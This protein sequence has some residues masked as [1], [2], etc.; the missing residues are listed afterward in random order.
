MN[1]ASTISLGR[2]RLGPYA[3]GVALAIV[4]FIALSAWWLLYDQRLPGAGDPGRHLSTTLGYADLLR[5]GDLLGMLRFNGDGE[6][7]YPPLVRWIGAV[8]AA[9]GLDVQDWGTLAVNLVFVPL[10]AA[11]C[12]LV[13]RR[14]YG[15][16]AGLLAALFALGTPMVL[17]LFHVFVLDAALAGIVAISLAA[18]LASE[19]FERRRESV[20]TGAL[21]GVGL[22][23]K[24]AAPIFLAAPIAVMLLLGA[25]RHWRNVALAAGAMLLVALPWHLFHLGDLGDLSGQAPSGLAPVGLG[26]EAGY[27]PDLIDRLAVYG[28]YGIN[29][30][31]FVPLLILFAIGF[32]AALRELRT[33]PYVPEL[34]AGVVAGYLAFALGVSLRDPRY[35]LPLVV[36]VAVIA[37]GWIATAPRPALRGAGIGLLAAAIALNVA[38]VTTDALPTMRVSAP[39]DEPNLGDLAQPGTFTF[40]DDAGYGIGPPRPNSLWTRLLDEAQRQGVR[41]TQIFVREGP[42]LGTDIIGFYVLAE[43]HG[44]REVS[45]AREPPKHPDMRVNVWWAT[46]DEY[47]IEEEGLPRPCGIVPDGTAAPEVSAPI[48][49]KVAVERREGGRYVRWCDF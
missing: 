1:D 41:T 10:L 43:Q 47:W 20:I 17:N 30:Q 22:M 6:F 4:A 5:D 29:L 37:T 21:I 40:V 42:R 12:Y 45:F 14:V 36:F 23:V 38:V 28:W 7:F 33:R 9:L 31:Y 24:T 3:A 34:L 8:P 49:L 35:T 27:A 48:A 16:L 25:W 39:G 13:G 44:I 18:L 2:L 11:G 26:G 15:P 19:R 46:P 32:V